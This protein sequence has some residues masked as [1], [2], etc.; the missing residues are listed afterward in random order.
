M[1]R[2]E[3]KIALVTGGSVGIGK[4]IVKQFAAEGAHVAFCARTEKTGRECES[5]LKNSGY[6]VSFTACDVTDEKAVNS[7]VGAVAAKKGYIDIVVSNAGTGRPRPWPDEKTESFDK[8]VKLN[9]YGMMYLCRAAWPYLIKSGKGS[10][11]AVT[12]LSAWMAVGRDQLECMGGGQPSAAYQASKAA[13]EGLAVH[14][15]GR[16]GEHNIRV[17]VIRPGRILTDKYE[18]S[19]GEEGI[20]WSHYKVMQLLKQHGRSIDIASAAV[21]LASDESGFIT[22]V[23]LDVNGGA[24]AKL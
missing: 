13:M 3:G 5:E 20:F 7:W 9:L 11:I 19:L 12:S 21:F 1:G 18:D 2:L 4:E 10:V 22:G 15:A 6:D 14:L 16:G 8:I 23:A 17:N 24:I